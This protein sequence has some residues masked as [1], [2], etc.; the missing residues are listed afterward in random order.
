MKLAVVSTFKCIDPITRMNNNWQTT[1]KCDANFVNQLTTT[2]T[3]TKTK[4]RAKSTR[5]AEQQNT[6]NTTKKRR[7]HDNFDDNAD[8]GYTL[9]GVVD[10][11]PQLLKERERG[12]RCK[13]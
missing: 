8:D 13:C 2:T 1:K 10:T 3:T 5:S 7:D 11:V 9:L 12:G 6:Q 4:K